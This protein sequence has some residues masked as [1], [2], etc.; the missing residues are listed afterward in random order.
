MLQT[1]Q[2]EAEQLADQSFSDDLLEI[3]IAL[4]R[5]VHAAEA[6]KYR[7]PKIKAR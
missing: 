2:R 1:A 5:V 3:N 7:S 4:A 6:A